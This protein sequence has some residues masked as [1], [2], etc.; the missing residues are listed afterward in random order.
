MGLT[1]REEASDGENDDAEVRGGGQP[2][3]SHAGPRE[4][5]AAPRKEGECGSVGREGD[6]GR[7]ETWTRPKPY[8]PGTVLLQAGNGGE[9][10]SPKIKKHR[11]KGRYPPLNPPP[12]LCRDMMAIQKRPPKPR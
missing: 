9:P 4:Q 12:R 6:V 7:L 2:C 10:L 5:I 11:Y 8:A 1:V 3:A